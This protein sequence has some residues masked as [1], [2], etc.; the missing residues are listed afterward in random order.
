MLKTKL[1]PGDRVAVFTGRD[2]TT[3]A[4]HG[5]VLASGFDTDSRTLI[6]FPHLNSYC[7]A[8]D[9]SLLQ[10]DS[11]QSDQVSFAEIVFAIC[12]SDHWCGTYRRLDERKNTFEF[13]RSTDGR[14][15]FDI[16][17]EITENGIGIGKSHLEIRIPGDVA[18]ETSGC[19][20]ILSQILRL[21]YTKLVSP[22]LTDDV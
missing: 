1:A 15:G 21:E 11:G 3:V 17:G 16:R 20:N 13:I 14:F 12:D 22:N 8:D 5:I 6:F 4:N 19:V 7:L 10:F 2:Y 18:L 9:E